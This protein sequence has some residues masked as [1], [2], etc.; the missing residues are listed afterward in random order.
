MRSSLKFYKKQRKRG[1]IMSST[2]ASTENIRRITEI[3]VETI[4][5]NSNQPRT[6]FE[7]ETL[8]SLS[9]SIARYGILQ[10]LTVRKIP[11]KS[12]FSIF[13]Y[14]LIAGERRLRASKLL[15]LSTVPCI[16]IDTDTK[17]SATL[18]II[19]NLHRDDLNVFEE[20]AAIASL[21]DLH[22]LTQEE[23]AK[24]LSLTQSAVANKLRLLRLSEG[25][26]TLILENGLTERH[27]R[28]LLKLKSPEERAAALGHIIKHSL[29]VKQSEEY[30]EKILTPEKK[31]EKTC[32]FD[33]KALFSYLKKTVESGRK[34]GIL[35]KTSH[36]ETDS[37][38]VYTVTFPKAPKAAV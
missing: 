31:E 3:K 32:V 12:Q 29:N 7:Q 20:A 18:A 17:T 10:P 8:K 15:G 6:E 11:E 33:H 19:E 21:I 16:I 36:T 38:I 24:E 28:A 9:E 35:V 30:I 27:A 13:Q 23:I 14:E 5:P 1:K 34:Q 22:K 37:E 26:K 4:M 25:E 2:D